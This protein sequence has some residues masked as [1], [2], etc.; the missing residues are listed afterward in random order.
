[1][2][3]TTVGVCVYVQVHVTYESE[4]FTVYSKTI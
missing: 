1:M 2:K 3:K 4:T